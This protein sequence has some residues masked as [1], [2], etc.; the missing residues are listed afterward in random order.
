MNMT[1]EV[2]ICRSLKVSDRRV[3]PYCIIIVIPATVIGN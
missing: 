2:T 3:N 1:F